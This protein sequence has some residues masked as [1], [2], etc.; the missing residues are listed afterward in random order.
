MNKKIILATV[1]NCVAYSSFALTG[2]QLNYLLTAP[3]EAKVLL[4]TTYLRGMLDSEIATVGMS[5]MAKASNRDF[6]PS[7][8]HYCPPDENDLEE[9]SDL[10]K[11]YL[12]NK[13]KNR[14]LPAAFVV[15]SAL[16]AKWPC[17]Y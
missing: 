1:L 13:P 2:T 5:I 16:A 10:V 11:Q 3:E 4:G 12:R 9:A 7:S 15:H 6:S 17:N 8:I 14:M